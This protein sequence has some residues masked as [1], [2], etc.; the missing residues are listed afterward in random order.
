M[1]SGAV[2]HSPVVGWLAR[3]GNGFWCLV[4]VAIGAVIYLPRLGSYPLWDP[5]EPH[6]LQVAWEMWERHT[7]L[8]PFYRG[9]DN[10]WSKPILL[11]WMLRVG[12]WF[13]DPVNNW[14]QA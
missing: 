3:R 12:M 9:E 13:W 10:W 5:W 7:W 2:E 1:K 11:L 4:L 6:Y 8:N 14:A